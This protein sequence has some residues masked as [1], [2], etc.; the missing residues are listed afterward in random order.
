MVATR[1]RNSGLILSFDL[2]LGEDGG[3]GSQLLHV[4]KGDLG[5]DGFRF[6]SV[7]GVED[8]RAG[9]GNGTDG[10]DATV[11]DGKCDRRSRDRRCY[12]NLSDPVQNSHVSESALRTVNW[13]GAESP[14]AAAVN[15]GRSWAGILHGVSDCESL[16]GA[17][18]GGP[19]SNSRRK[20][21]SCAREGEQRRGGVSAAEKGR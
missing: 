3:I 21:G 11:G 2:T 12:K 5:R 15:P 18:V 7:R 20:R 10:R 19:R 13:D 1:K 17:D 8:K 9:H 16:S 14:S 6:R 4:R